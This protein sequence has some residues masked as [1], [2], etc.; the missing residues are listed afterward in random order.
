MADTRPSSFVL[1]CVYV[2]SL[3]NFCYFA[4]SLDLSCIEVKKE[5]LELGFKDENS[6]PISPTSGKY[7]TSRNFSNAMVYFFIISFIYLVSSEQI[8][9]RG[10]DLAF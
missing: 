9:S 3:A 5:Y 2:V 8:P 4:Q 7:Y 1:F 10:H 6:V